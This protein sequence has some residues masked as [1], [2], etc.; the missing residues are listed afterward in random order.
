MGQTHHFEQFGYSSFKADLK[1]NP[2]PKESDKMH[3]FTRFAVELNEWEE[4]VA[5]TDSRNRP[6]QRV[7]EEGD[8][9]T[10]NQLKQK[11]EEAQRL[12]RKEREEQGITYKPQWFRIKEA[13]E[14]IDDNDIYAFDERYLHC[15]Q[16]GDWSECL[17]IFDV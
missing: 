2:L 1:V 8:W 10:A 15:K 4:G 17:H 13:N 16:K 6:D 12:R 11:L 3:N 5:P 7:M 9:S 14:R